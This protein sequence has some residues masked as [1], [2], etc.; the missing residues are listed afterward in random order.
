MQVRMIPSAAWLCGGLFAAAL[1]LH[2]QNTTTSAQMSTTS[3]PPVGL[4]STETAQVNVV[5]AAPA[6]A[7]AGTCTGSIAFYN[8]AG[9]I[10][11][12]ATDF[13]VT[14]GEIASVALP[15]ASAQATGDARIVVRAEISLNFNAPT[16]AGAAPPACMLGGSLETYDT[17]SGVTHMFFSLGTLVTP[18]AAVR[19]GV[20]GGLQAR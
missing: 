12:S 9:A 16:A 5:N 15:Y 8:A 17:S 4:A 1:F 7:G 10:I 6:S 13:K 14:T 2:G 19:T 3:L 18:L 11:G 20:I